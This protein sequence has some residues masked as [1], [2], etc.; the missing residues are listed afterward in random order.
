MN[1]D[2]KQ[3]IDEESILAK[4]SVCYPL[5][6]VIFFLRDEKTRI[7]PLETFWTGCVFPE[8]I[9]PDDFDILK[10]FWVFNQRHCSITTI[11][12]TR[13]SGQPNEGK[14]QLIGRYKY[15]ILGP[16]PP[17]F[18]CSFLNTAPLQYVS[19]ILFTPAIIDFSHHKQN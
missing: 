17:K 6:L 14:L 3:L 5:F 8:N 2:S 10:M 12:N 13:S 4:L 9:R 1:R 11:D 16:I 15:C 18:Y 7:L 19:K